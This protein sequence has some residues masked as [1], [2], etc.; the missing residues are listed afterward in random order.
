MRQAHRI[1]VA[2]LDWAVVS[3]LCSL[4]GIHCLFWFWIYRV[5]FFR[6][7]FQC[8]EISETASSN[9]LGCQV[10][11]L[12]LVVEYVRAAFAPLRRLNSKLAK[13]GVV[14]DHPLMEQRLTCFFRSNNILLELRLCCYIL[15]EWSCCNFEC[16][17]LHFV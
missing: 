10:R 2:S 14:T 16:C 3:T 7:E 17:L 6:L 12:N 9:S 1:H 4:C 15:C 11:K 8:F 5:Y 13:F